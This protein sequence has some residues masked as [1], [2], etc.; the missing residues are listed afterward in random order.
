MSDDFGYCAVPPHLPTSTYVTGGQRFPK[1]LFLD[2]KAGLWLP[3]RARQCS[4]H[5][6]QR[7]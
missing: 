5:A 1:V 7:Y 2:P 4:A 3:N 6:F